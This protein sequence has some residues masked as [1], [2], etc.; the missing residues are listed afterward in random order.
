MSIWP[1]IYTLRIYIHH[2]LIID[3]NRYENTLN[4]L[5]TVKTGAKMFS[6]W[7]TEKTNVENFC[8][9]D[10]L[11]A[12]DTSHTQPTEEKWGGDFLGFTVGERN[13]KHWAIIS[14]FFSLRSIC[15]VLF[16]F[17]FLLV[18]NYKIPQ[19]V[20]IQNLI[21]IKHDWY[22]AFWQTNSC[23]S[24]YTLLNGFASIN[25]AQFMFFCLSSRFFSALVHV[26]YSF[27]TSSNTQFQQLVYYNF[28][29]S[30]SFESS[31]ERLL[32]FFSRNRIGFCILLCCCFYFFYFACL[33]KHTML[34]LF[35]SL[36]Y[37]Q[38][39]THS[40]QPSSIE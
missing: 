37:R 4:K 17:F 40:P 8:I 24:L 14:N 2:T 36:T 35:I 20:K 25:R 22:F 21:L 6:M 3:D 34:H 7:P 28:I 31:S 23:F 11:Y 32:L 19:I 9:Y 27:S 18:H 39:T 5:F 15:S 33:T 10:M 38:P 16:S 12:L 26:Q 13:I 29:H 30:N 1:L